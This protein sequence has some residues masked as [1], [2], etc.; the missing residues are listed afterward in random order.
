MPRQGDLDGRG[1]LSRRALPEFTAWFL[2]VCLDRVTL[3][4]SLF[5]QDTLANRLRRYAER[6]EFKHEA[7]ALLEHAL[8][9]G[10][11]PRGDAARITGLRERTARDLL[12]ALTTDGILGSATPKGPASLRFPLHAAEV[13]FSRLFPEA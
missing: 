5:G 10:E 3:M 7:F 12:G 8:Q 1:N 11:F 9:R 13:L 6:R 2:S 4:D